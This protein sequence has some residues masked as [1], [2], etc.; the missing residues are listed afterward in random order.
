MSILV[1]SIKM[2]PFH[3]TNDVYK[4]NFNTFWLPEGVILLDV[5]HKVNHKTPQYLNIPILIQT[6]FCN[7]SRSSPLSTRELAG[8]HEETQEV[9]WN[10]VQCGNARLLP[11]ILE[12]T[13]LQLEPDTKPPLRSIPNADIPEE[14][15]AQPQELQDQKY[16]NTVSQTATDIGRTNL[17]EL[18]NSTEDSPITS[19]PYTVPLKYHEFA[20]HKFKQLEEVGIIPRSMSNW[21]SPIPVVPKKEIHMETGNNTSGSKNM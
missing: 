21:A 7:I 9:S 8:K 11:E 14:A 2:P 1:I 15:R 19:K 12:G 13:S 6:S 4:L 3:N 20:H 18:D 5:L 17:I 16:I 10:Q